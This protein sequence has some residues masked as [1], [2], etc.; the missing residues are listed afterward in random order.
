[1]FA[2]SKIIPTFASAFENKTPAKAQHSD[3]K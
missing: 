3:Q 2:D 1:M